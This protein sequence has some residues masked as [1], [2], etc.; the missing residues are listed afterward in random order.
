MPRAHGAA[1]LGLGLAGVEHLATT[2]DCYSRA[3]GGTV[4]LTR[5]LAAPPPKRWWRAGSVNVGVEPS[6]ESGDRVGLREN[7]T[8]GALVADGLGHG[9]EAARA[10]RAAVSTFEA[11]QLQDLGAFVRRAHEAMRSTRGGALAACLIDPDRN[12]LLHVGVGNVSGQVLRDGK[13]E[14]LLGRDGSLGTHLPFPRVQV[15]EHRWA[16]GSTLVLCTDGLRSGI[17][18]LAYPGLLQHDPAIVAAVLHRD[19]GRATDDACVLVV[20]DLRTARR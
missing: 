7:G 4:A 20:A 17:E 18:P 12:S 10:A 3:P 8:L 6:G 13:S 1:G 2:F 5:L 15:G 16:P 11:E 19:F 9:P 14:H